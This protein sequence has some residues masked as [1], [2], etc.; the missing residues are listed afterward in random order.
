MDDS[1]FSL[2]FI[3]FTFEILKGKNLIGKESNC[4]NMFTILTINV[5]SRSHGDRV[6]SA[7]GKFIPMN[8]NQFSR[9]LFFYYTNFRSNKILFFIIYFFRINYGTGWRSLVRGH[10][11]FTSMLIV[12]CAK[13]HSMRGTGTIRTES[14]DWAMGS[15]WKR[16]S[17]PLHYWSARG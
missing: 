3:G 11:F 13:W 9:C 1:L 5:N 6:A 16:G 14:W 10:H 2:N 8:K 4:D 15:F 7:Y 17:L 12:I